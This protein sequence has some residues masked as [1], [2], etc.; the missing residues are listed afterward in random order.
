MASGLPN[1]IPSRVRSSPTP[2]LADEI[3]DPPL[4]PGA[5]HREGGTV[6]HRILALFAANT[7]PRVREIGA[8]LVAPK[9]SGRG[10]AG[11]AVPLRMTSRPGGYEP[12]VARSGSDELVVVV[13]ALGVDPSDGPDHVGEMHRPPAT[14]PISK[15]SRSAGNLVSRRTN[16]PGSTVGTVDC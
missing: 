7:G 15:L 8:A 13:L 12:G 2:A 4:Q 3:S 9:T 10:G 5:S 6:N 14:R 16:R 1:R 11:W